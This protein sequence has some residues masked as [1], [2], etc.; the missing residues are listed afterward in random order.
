MFPLLPVLIHFDSKMTSLDNT[1]QVFAFRL[2]QAKI[3]TYHMFIIVIS[4][5][6][7]MSR[8]FHQANFKILQLAPYFTGS[9][10]QDMKF[11]FLIFNFLFIFLIFFTANT[12]AIATPPPA[13]KATAALIAMPT[14]TKVDKVPALAVAIVIIKATTPVSNKIVA[15]LPPTPCPLFLLLLAPFE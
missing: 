13:A 15:T 12:V 10:M 4:K 2:E 14:T 11:I 1:A 6:V 8:C 5:F 9:L 3:F 7:H